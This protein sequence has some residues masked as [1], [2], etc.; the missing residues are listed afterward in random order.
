MRY[1]VLNSCHLCARPLGS[2]I[3][4]KT[5]TAPNIIGFKPDAH[6]DWNRVTCDSRKG[7]ISSDKMLSNS[8]INITPNIGP[9]EVPKPPIIIIPT[10]K[11]DSLKSKNSGFKKP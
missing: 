8:L 7:T 3:R 6:P 10:Y 11:I 5:I 9:T 2:S 1:E 4:N